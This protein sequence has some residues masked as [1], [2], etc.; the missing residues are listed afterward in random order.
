MRPRCT[1]WPLRRASATMSRHSRT[2][3]S[4]QTPLLRRLSHSL[5]RAALA[6]GLL[7]ISSFDTSLATEAKSSSATLNSS[8]LI[9]SFTS[10]RILG[11]CSIVAGAAVFGIAGT[12]NFWE[13]AG[14][15]SQALPTSLAVAGGHWVASSRAGEDFFFLPLLPDDGAGFSSCS[16]AAFLASSSMIR[17]SVSCPE[18]LTS[19]TVLSRSLPDALNLCSYVQSGDHPNENHLVLF[20][21]WGSIWDLGIQALGVHRARHHCRLVEASL[22]RIHTHLVADANWTREAQLWVS[23]ESLDLRGGRLSVL[24]SQSELSKERWNPRMAIP[25]FSFFELSVHPSWHDSQRLPTWQLSIHP[26]NHDLV[27]C[28]TQGKFLDLML[29]RACL[30]CYLPFWGY[31]RTTLWHQMGCALQGTLHQTWVAM[32]IHCRQ[33]GGLHWSRSHDA[34]WPMATSSKG[35][36]IATSCCGHLP[37]SDELRA[38]QKTWMNLHI[39]LMFDVCNPNPWWPWSILGNCQYTQLEPHPL[40]QWSDSN[41]Q[42][43]F[44]NPWTGLGRHIGIG[45]ADLSTPMQLAPPWNPLLHSSWWWHGHR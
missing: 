20:R 3:F 31:S 35:V 41:H 16:L 15:I 45:C 23:V 40:I 43:N 18:G 36:R 39:R 17:W 21:L 37:T 22:A 10:S 30:M 2:R 34:A 42:H 32:G 28:N 5:S 33:A 44:V 29:G 27:G 1:V 24:S 9:F 4:S 14:M 13:A 6:L 7:A 19:S 12:E 11:R 38:Q 8:S 26:S 25:T